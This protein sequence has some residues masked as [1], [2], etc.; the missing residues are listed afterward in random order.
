MTPRTRLGQ[1]S[2][3]LAEALSAAETVASLTAERDELLREVRDLQQQLA[4]ANLCIGK[5]GS[6]GEDDE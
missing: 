5:R 1:G 6:I 4:A 2:A 3:A